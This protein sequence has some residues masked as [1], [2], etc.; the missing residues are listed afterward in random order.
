MILEEQQ[1][2]LGNIGQVKKVTAKELKK[3]H[4][5][6][7]SD[8]WAKLT[9]YDVPVLYPNL[10]VA[11]SFKNETPTYSVQLH[12]PKD[13]T[14]RL[15]GTNLLALC[16]VSEHFM[17]TQGINIYELNVDQGVENPLL[18]DG[19]SK[20]NTLSFFDRS[21]YCSVKKY[22][23]PDPNK[24]PDFRLY[25]I[26]NENITQKVYEARGN[27]D[28]LMNIPTIGDGDRVNVR[29]NLLFYTW[30][31]TT[32]GISGY[33][34]LIR[35]IHESKQNY[36]L[37]SDQD[38]LRILEPNSLENDDLNLE[39]PDFMKHYMGSLKN[40]IVSET[41]EKRKEIKA[42]NSDNEAIEFLEQ[43]KEVSEDEPF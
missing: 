15:F 28:S 23:N 36:R 26:K 10:L 2:I 22:N 27:I 4:N 24:M 42:F 8:K 21:F 7:W 39:N 1:E 5:I 31:S 25:N 13:P 19:S 9:L 6:Q 33:L 30:G 20:D 43:Q 12:F 32:K 34:D 37:G 16:L 35:V 14:N 40:Q 3:K 38:N 18:K 29:I 17:Q 41:S 11:K